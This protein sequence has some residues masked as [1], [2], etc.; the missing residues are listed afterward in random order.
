MRS[1]A[2][3]ALSAAVLFVAPQLAS[4]QLVVGVNTSSSSRVASTYI[5]LSSDPLTATTLWAGGAS[6]RGV[7][8]IA[9]DD[10]NGR[11]YSTTGARLCV[12]KYGTG[13]ASV[14][15]TTVAGVYRRYNGG[16]NFE[17]VAI[18]DLT[19]ANGNLYGWEE[20]TTNMPRGIYQIPT[21]AEA[22]GRIYSTPLWTDTNSQSDAFKFEG[23]TFNSSNNLFYGVNSQVNPATPGG[24]PPPG[25]PLGIYTID[26]FGT[27]A[28]TKIADLPNIDGY[29]KWDGMALGGGKLWISLHDLANS[30][31]LI[32]SYDLATG[33][34]DEDLLGL[35]YSDTAARGTGLTWANVNPTPEPAALAA[36]LV[37]AALLM[38][39]RR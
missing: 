25:Q 7:Y 12:W 17:N 38:G 3:A 32:A 8:G 35:P 27:G 2:F 18:Q 19:F 14:G 34:Y 6:T 37:P 5:N 23:I 33:T 26:A 36:L 24:T 11:F 28:A 21:A 29:V 20:S 15:P 10:A 39:R 1:F 16:A 30:Q 31:I 22:D 9:A 4:A 13:P